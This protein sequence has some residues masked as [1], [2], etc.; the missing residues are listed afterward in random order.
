VRQPLADALRGGRYLTANPADDRELRAMLAAW[1]YLRWGIALVSAVLAVELLYHFGP[2][3][4]QSDRSNCCRHY[5]GWFVILARELL[6]ALR[7]S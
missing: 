7:E 1:R 6:P 3:V 2:D 4:K 5:L